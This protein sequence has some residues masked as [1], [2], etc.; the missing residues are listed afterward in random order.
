M[1]EV[2]LQVQH[3]LGMDRERALGRIGNA[4]DLGIAPTALVD[5]PDNFDTLAASRQH[6]DRRIWR[7]FYKVKELGGITQKR[8]STVTVEHGMRRHSSM[9]TAANPD[10]VNMRCTAHDLRS[11]LKR[12][13]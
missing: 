9:P 1:I 2:R 8:R 6:D 7:N 3:N 13:V 5:K 12:S 4:N 11:S 10:D